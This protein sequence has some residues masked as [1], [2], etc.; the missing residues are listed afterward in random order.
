MKRPGWL[1]GIA[2]AYGRCSGTGVGLWWAG[3]QA[4]QGDGSGHILYLARLESTAVK[5]VVAQIFQPQCGVVWSA[6]GLVAYAGG[7]DLAD[8][9]GMIPFFEGLFEVAFEPGGAA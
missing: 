3:S 4:V 2:A 7:S 5:Y 6:I 1:C 9:D 8:E